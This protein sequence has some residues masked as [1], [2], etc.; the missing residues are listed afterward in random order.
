MECIEKYGRYFVPSIKSLFREY[1]LEIPFIM[2]LLDENC[3]D[4]A[5]QHHLFHDTEPV[6]TELADQCRN[7]MCLV[8]YVDDE[9]ATFTEIGKT[10]GVTKQAIQQ[11]EGRA[12]GKLRQTIEEGGED[13]ICDLMSSL[14]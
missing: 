5:C 11:A 6:N 3:A 9:L 12:M 13:Q 4:R 14:E 10:L 7:C 2:I 1:G 8:Q